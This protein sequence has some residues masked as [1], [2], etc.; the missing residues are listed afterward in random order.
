VE[1]FS[2]FWQAEYFFIFTQPFPCG[3][4]FISMKTNAMR[5]IKLF[6][7]ILPAFMICF[8]CQKPYTLPDDLRV[9]NT[10]STHAGLL[11]KEVLKYIPENFEN[12][13]F[14][15]GYDSA[16]KL[17]QRYYLAKI[18]NPDGSI[19]TKMDTLYYHRDALGRLIRI[20]ELTDSIYLNVVYDGQSTR[21]KEA[22]DNLDNYST[23]F[24]YDANGR[25]K[26]LNFFMRT[27]TSS[28]PKRKVSYHD[29][30]YDAAGNLVEK[31]F[32]Q[33]DNLTGNFASPIRFLFEYDNK[34]NPRY[35]VDDVLFPETWSLISPNNNTRQ[36]NIYADPLML[37][38]T[39]NYSY[40]YDNK[41]RP[42]K[43]TKNGDTETAYFYY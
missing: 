23:T 27:P 9:L 31:I 3:N 41:D 14:E 21:V 28:D 42:V 39:I 17:S 4:P 35:P 26:R 8:A 12:M 11:K 38:D 25:I 29:H 37:K 33:D 24:E 43:S 1:Y 34:I 30:V 20:G 22:N 40:T 7:A 6:L 18:K 32:Y 15:Y 10:D 13:F 36:I 2:G 5:S 16:G 19:T